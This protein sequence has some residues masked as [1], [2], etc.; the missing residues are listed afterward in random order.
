MENNFQKMIDR[1]VV[2]K[3]KYHE[4][5]S[6]KWGVEQ[7]MAGLVTDIG[8]LNEIVMIYNG[9][10]ND[11]NGDV[12][13]RLKHELS[14]VLYSL[15]ILANKTGIDLEKEFDITMDELEKRLNK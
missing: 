1:A 11:V 7:T 10:R 3:N 8:E 13:K 2:I 6:K 9:Y 4:R 12:E 5:E 14:D 15:M